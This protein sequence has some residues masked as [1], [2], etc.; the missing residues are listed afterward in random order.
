VNRMERTTL[1]E[2]LYS[3]RKSW[4]LR[5]RFILFNSM[6]EVVETATLKG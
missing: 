1:T 2:A 4:R 6:G 3:N 5:S